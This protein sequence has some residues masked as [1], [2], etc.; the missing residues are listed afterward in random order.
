MARAVSPPFLFQLLS[1]SLEATQAAGVNKQLS[2]WT[3][4]ELSIAAV[5]VVLHL[6]AV[7]WFD[8]QTP[9]IPAGHIIRRVM[10]DGSLATIDKS[11]NDPQT[12]ADRQVETK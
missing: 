3:K 6:I 4:V 12:E 7:L 9:T 8:E 5:L 1:V 10:R 2:Q 11:V